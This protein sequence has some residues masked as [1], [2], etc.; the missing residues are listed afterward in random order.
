MANYWKQWLALSTV[1][2]LMTACQSID[3]MKLRHAKAN[4]ESK[5]NALI[6]CTGTPDCQ[7][8]R[9]NQTIIVKADNG[10]ISD[11]AQKQKLV[12]LQAKNL[13]QV[14]PIYLSVPAGQHE[15][16]VRFYPITKDKAETL[17]VFHHFQATK[18][19]TLKM[20]R[21]RSA[22]SS[23]LLNAS[24]PDPLC[25][26]LVQEQKTIRRFCKPY[27]VVNGIAEFVEKKI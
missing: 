15:L 24:A 14:N 25:V 17:H 5:N 1:S 27:N 21:D 22:R 11:A 3:T 7:F 19:Y 6:Y 4:I 2:V 13:N 16:V 9:L 18:T 23:S 20:F 12:R 26:D 10:R 8:E